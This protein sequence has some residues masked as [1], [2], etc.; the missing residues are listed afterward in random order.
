MYPTIFKWKLRLEK[1]SEKKRTKLVA[2]L[3]ELLGFK[4]LVV[5]DGQMFFNA[6]ES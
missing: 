1:E 5:Q 3:E 2:Q 6:L 4:V